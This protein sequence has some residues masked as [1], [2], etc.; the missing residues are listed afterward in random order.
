MS[1]L[2]REIRTMFHRIIQ[3]YRIR[4]ADLNNRLRILIRHNVHQPNLNHVIRI[5]PMVYEI[6]MIFKTMNQWSF[7]MN[8]EQH[9]FEQRISLQRRHFQAML[10]VDIRNQQIFQHRHVKVCLREMISM[11]CDQEFS[12][13]LINRK[14]SPIIEIHQWKNQ[15]SMR[16]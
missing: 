13:I 7:D 14:K 4:K 2:A 11:K 16:N 10:V 15:V 6:H 3:H 5:L 12:A 1:I 8:I 9:L